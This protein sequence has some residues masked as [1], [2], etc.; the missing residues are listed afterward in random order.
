MVP[1]PASLMV[2][3][4]VDESRCSLVIVIVERRQFRSDNGIFH[5]YWSTRAIQR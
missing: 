4:L 5:H 2:L 3:A 1:N